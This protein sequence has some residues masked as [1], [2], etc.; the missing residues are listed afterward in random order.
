MTFFSCTD[1]GS[2]IHENQPSD[3]NFDIYDSSEK[4][5]IIQFFKEVALGTEYGDNFQVTQKWSHAMNI[6]VGGSQNDELLSE[7]KLI[8]NEINELVTNG[9][10]VNIVNDSLQSNFYLF[11]GSP[12]DYTNLF[13]GEYENVIVNNFGL[14]HIYTDHNFE[15][16]SGHM[17]VNSYLED[18]KLKKHILRE[19]LTQSLGLPK[20]LQYDLGNIFVG[21][22]F[23]AETFTNAIKNSIF[24]EGMSSL[25]SYN[26]ADKLIIRLLYQPN[27]SAGLDVDRVDGVLRRILG[28]AS[29]IEVCEP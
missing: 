15:I 29:T 12:Q 17:Y 8:K 10:S 22:D 2:Y 24:Y 25:N 19:E 14:F 20:D 16:I 9:F 1:A 13:P 6:F 23:I 11:F 26:W 21:C 18:P 7:L 3:N 4:K 28:V 27:M 5:S